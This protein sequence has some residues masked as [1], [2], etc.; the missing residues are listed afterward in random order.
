MG[1]FLDEFAESP[2]RSVEDIIK[3]NG[4]HRSKCLPEGLTQP[5]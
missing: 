2:V 4:Q 1:L 5:D 3:Y